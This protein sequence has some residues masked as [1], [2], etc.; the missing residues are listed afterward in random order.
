M[1][2]LFFLLLLL[3]L[4]CDSGGDADSDAATDMLLPSDLGSAGEGGLPEGDADVGEGGGS[5]DQGID[6][7]QLYCNPQSRFGVIQAAKESIPAESAQF[8]PRSAFTGSGWGLLW[9]IPKENRLNTLLFQRFDRDGRAQGSPLEVGIARSPQLELLYD[10][11]RFVAVW[12]S[13]EVSRVGLSYRFISTE[14]VLQGESVLV[15]GSY[16]ATHFAAAWAPSAGGM[17]LHTGP[18]GVFVIPVDRDG[19]SLLAQRVWEGAAKGAALSYGDGYWGLAWLGQN[20]EHP[21]KDLMFVSVDDDGV[22][23]AAPQRIII[24]GGQADG[25]VHM[26]YGEG[27]YGVGWS[28]QGPTGLTPLLTLFA[29]FDVLAHPP[30]A[31]PEN[32]GLVTDLTWLPSNK[33]GVAWIDI[34]DEVSVGLT[35]INGGGQVDPALRLTPPQG[36]EYRDMVVGGSMTRAGGWY[37]HEPSPGGN[38]FSP[39][40][41]IKFIEFGPCEP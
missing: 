25:Y 22:V 20:P 26:A 12:R 35:T 18:D 36:E 4:G 32:Y 27:N 38:V 40:A 37:V 31:G 5:G 6:P 14:G 7:E 21:Q 1:P 10:G 3:S 15:E 33:F 8:S 34:G 11:E 19:S 30:V 23:L 13:E 29:G 28:L 39:E 17:L 2:R 41:R 16:S 24:P 9:Q